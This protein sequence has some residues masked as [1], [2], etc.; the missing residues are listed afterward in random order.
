MKL[1]RYALLA[2]LLAL[3]AALVGSGCHR[4]ASSPRRATA[5]ASGA[6]PSASKSPSG[7]VALAAEEGFTDTLSDK[8]QFTPNVA[9]YQVQADLGNIANLRLFQE[10]LKPDHRRRLA[11][12]GFVVVPAQW[13]QMEFIYEVNNYPREHLPSFVTVDSALHTWH[14]FYDYVLRTIEV[15]TL[16]DRLDSLGQGLAEQAAQQYAQ[17]SVPEVREA[18]RA[19]YAFCLVPIRL[20]HQGEA[21]PEGLG[22]PPPEVEELVKAEL[23]LIAAHPDFRAS[24]TVGFKVDYSQFVPRGHYTRSEKLKRYFGAMMWY[25]LVP[26][27]LRNIKDELAPQQARQSVLLAEALLQ[28]KWK[29]QPLLTVWDSIYEPT[30]FMVGFADDLAP[31]DFGQVIPGVFGDPPDAQKLVPEENLQAYVEA[32]L[33]LPQPRIKMA[34]I[35]QDPELPGWP[36]LRLMGQ[37]FV[38]DSYLEQQMVFPFVGKGPGEPN[39]PLEFNKRTFPM[40]LD[41]MSILGSERAY[42]I[43]DQVYEQTRYDNYQQQSLKLRGEVAALEPTKWTSNA[44][45]GWLDAFRYL[46]EA[47][48][49]GYP[50]FMAGEAWTDKQ[51]NAALASW[52]ELRHDTILY[53]KQSVVV[54]CGGEGGEQKP[55]PPPKGYIEPEVLTYWRLRH[56]ATQLQTGLE[57]RQLL[58]DEPLK[59]SFKELASLLTFL[60]QASVKELTGVALS[61]E[62]YQQIEYYGDALGRLNL[63]TKQGT[64]GDEITSMTDKDMAVVADVHTGVIGFDNYALE[65]GVGHANEVYAVYPCEGELLLGRGATFS[66]YEFTQPVADRL[67]DEAWQESLGSNEPPKAPKWVESFRSNTPREGDKELQTEGIP[68]YARGGC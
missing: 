59:E 46:L 5:G 12:D 10:M 63:Y 37:R 39:A 53:A 23:A 34:S 8:P 11:K 64:Q 60:E 27:A 40:G 9:P 51:L 17:A 67:T 49:D 56:V 28:G 24:P 7:S 45:Y 57:Q 50:S 6:L 44:Y 66:Y 19:N 54:E 25:G 61:A 48:R 3:V 52:A 1:H 65:E 29:D 43:A 26:V 30:A 14:V 36:Q 2:V 32:L 47:K 42:Q 4:G 18:A 20:L 41:V 68:D 21:G 15:T 22:S 62:E 13:K 33:K 31:L 38:L 55:P 35:L 58:T 16:Y